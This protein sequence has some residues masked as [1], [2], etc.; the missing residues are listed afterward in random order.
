LGTWRWE[1]G[2]GN[3]ALETFFCLIVDFVWYCYKITTQQKVLL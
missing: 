3:L 2:V 1:P